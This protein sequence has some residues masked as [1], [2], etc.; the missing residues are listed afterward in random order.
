ML[1][2]VVVLVCL[3]AVPISHAAANP[4]PAATYTVTLNGTE[5]SSAPGS[6][7]GSGA[8]GELAPLPNPSAHAH[9]NG[10]G[11]T[12]AEMI[13]WFR[14]D[15]PVPDA[16]VPVV[17][18]GQLHISAGGAVFAQNMVWG[19]TA[20]LIAQ[21]YDGQLFGGSPLSQVDN[22]FQ[23]VDCNP[24]SEGP[25]AT[26]PPIGSCAATLQDATVVL[27]LDTLTG[28]DNRVVLNAAANNQEHFVANFD[29]LVDPIISFAPGF[30]PTGYT[31]LLSDGVGNALP[32]P[33][34]AALLGM[35]GA[36][37]LAR[38]LTR[39]GEGR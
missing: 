27:H 30:D 6:F 7:G 20:Q 22:Q 12:F 39:P 32:E 29:S 19:T 33:G 3:A 26:P 8:L 18:T 2:R 11:Q 21:S 23:S 37:V 14:I 1:R 31:I 13:Y 5:V 9:V 17:I 36:L 15:G 16:H 10:V 38:R 4:L 25:I 28:A 35:A 34:T 24:A